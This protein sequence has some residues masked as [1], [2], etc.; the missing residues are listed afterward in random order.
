M[1]YDKTTHANV[2]LDHHGNCPNCGTS[3]DAGDIFDVLRQQAVYC[4]RSDEQLR[5][6]VQKYYSPPYKFSRIIGIEYAYDH[7]Q[8]YDGVSEWQCPDCK[9]S[10]YRFKPQPKKSTTA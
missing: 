5:A 1:A 10:W 9:Y 3:W 6:T 7:P 8:H 4:D 2:P